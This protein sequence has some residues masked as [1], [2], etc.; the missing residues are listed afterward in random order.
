MGSKYVSFS[1]TIFRTQ[2]Y[3]DMKVL[4]NKWSCSNSITIRAWVS[5]NT[6]SIKEERGR[7][8]C[9]VPFV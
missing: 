1:Q 8:R 7:H 4:L 9:H 6:G 2:K 5:L 3:W